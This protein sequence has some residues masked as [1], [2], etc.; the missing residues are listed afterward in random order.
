[1]PMIMVAA[2][3]AVDEP[4][5]LPETT[6]MEKFEQETKTIAV[7]NLKHQNTRNLSF[8]SQTNGK[9]SHTSKE[10]KRPSKKAS[11]GWKSCVLNI[12]NSVIWDQIGKE[13]VEELT[14]GITGR[15]ENQSQTQLALLDKD[16][17]E[18]GKYSSPQPPTKPG[19]LKLAYAIFESKFITCFDF[20][21]FPW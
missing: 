12:P 15:Y 19:G 7:Q 6:G 1:M 11:M 2:K 8:T 3:G 18:S 10:I 9:M 4:P 13:D 16:K 20:F 17:T 21:P 5:I 14:S